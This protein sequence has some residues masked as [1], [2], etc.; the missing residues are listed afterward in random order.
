MLIEGAC[1]N[2]HAL[3]CALHGGRVTGTLVNGSLRGV[4]PKC[5][6]RLHVHHESGVLPVTRL[7][8]IPAP[9]AKQA[10]GG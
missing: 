6:G 3:V 1:D 2:G 9:E 5:G 8:D 10:K 7:A 4:C